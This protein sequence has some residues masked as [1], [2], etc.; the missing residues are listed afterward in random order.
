MIVPLLLVSLA[1]AQPEGTWSAERTSHFVF[2]HEN[3]G[4]P[5]GDENAL[6][7]IY[8]S[9]HPALWTLVPWMTK[10]KVSV[11]VYAGRESFLKGRFHPPP[12]SGGL[13]SSTADEKALAVF[14]PVDQAVA[15]HELTHLYF[16][17]YF[18]EKS[19]RPP[20]WLDEGLAEM[21]KSSALAPPDPRD[22]GPVLPAPMPLKDFLNARPAQDSPDAAVTAWY[23]QAHSVVRFLRK[24]HVESLFAGFCAKLRDGSSLETALRESY[25]YA[26]L[27]AF[28][29]AWLKWRP[30]KAPGQF[31]GLGEL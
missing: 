30:K 31:R 9:L 20:A 19:V 14:A 7:R 25:G 15:A 4:V 27:D 11:Y 2:H 21:L 17:A 23:L 22:D 3:H 18:D 16:H 12:W 1:A 8:E 6:E 28:E 13:M 24:A 5:L 29:R 26:D 10:E